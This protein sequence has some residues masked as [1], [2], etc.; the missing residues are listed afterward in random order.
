MNG[1]HRPRRFSWFSRSLFAVLG[2]FV[3]TVV[4]LGLLALIA[5]WLWHASAFKWIYQFAVSAGL[6]VLGL[7]CLIISSGDR[8]Q[9]IHWGLTLLILSP[10]SF[11]VTNWIFWDE[12]RQKFRSFFSNLPDSPTLPHLVNLPNLSLPVHPDIPAAPIAILALVV[13]NAAWFANHVPARRIIAGNVLV[14]A[15]MVAMYWLWAAGWRP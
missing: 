2:F 5:S 14:T 1:Y 8:E 9:R 11:V 13:V 10:I 7:Y 4:S 12:H 6:L 15:A 3:A